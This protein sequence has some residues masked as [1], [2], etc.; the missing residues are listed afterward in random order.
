M[1]DMKKV[2]KI[3]A[4]ITKEAEEQLLEIVKAS[5]SSMS[6]IIM[7]AIQYY[8]KLELIQ[9]SS[10]AYEIAKKNKLIGCAKGPKNLSIRYKQDLLRTLEKKHDLS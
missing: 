6:E 7:Q 9:S 3:N 1:Y 10:S 5:G 4:R 8:Y 2:R